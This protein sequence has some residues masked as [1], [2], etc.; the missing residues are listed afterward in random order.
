[1]NTA[2]GPAGACPEIRKDRCAREARPK[3]L[4]NIH[5]IHLIAPVIFV[6]ILMVHWICSSL[7]LMENGLNHLRMDDWQLISL[8]VAITVV[9]NL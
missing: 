5:V 6:I 8:R 7:E 4:F 9:I 1:M 2:S 3:T